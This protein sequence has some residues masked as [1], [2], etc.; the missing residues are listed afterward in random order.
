[1]KW[2]KYECMIQVSQVGKIC[3]PK[4]I[5]YIKLNLLNTKFIFTMK[6]FISLIN[7]KFI[8]MM[9]HLSNL[10]NIN[11]LNADKKISSDNFTK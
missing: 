10:V 2:Y 3:R 5:F 11:F 9:K 8:F 7:S 4:N 6:F 1:M